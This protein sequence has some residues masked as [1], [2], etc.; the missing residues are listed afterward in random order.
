MGRTDVD[1][2]EKDG[3]AE[4]EDLSSA[5]CGVH[6]DLIVLVEYLGRL[7]ELLQLNLSPIFWV[8]S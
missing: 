8:A 3:G 2:S 1:T 7:T 6:D 5:D 4:A